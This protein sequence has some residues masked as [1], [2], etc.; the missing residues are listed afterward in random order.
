MYEVDSRM[1]NVWS[2]VSANAC[3]ILVVHFMKYSDQTMQLV[4]TLVKTTG[5]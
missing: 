2:M 5:R 1:Q 3:G 4:L